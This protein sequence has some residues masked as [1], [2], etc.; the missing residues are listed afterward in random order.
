MSSPSGTAAPSVTRTGPGAMRGL[1]GGAISA[2]LPDTFA[3]VSAI[4]E[5][6]DHQE[7]F[8]GMQGSEGRE[9]SLIVE[10]LERDDALERRT[11]EDVMT[12]YFTD[13]AAHNESQGTTVLFPAAKMRASEGFM[14]C[15]DQS[16]ARLLIIGRQHVKKYRSEHSEVD[17]VLVLLALVR[18]GNVATDVLISMNI[19][20][21]P[22]LPPT[23]GAG[24]EDKALGDAIAQMM[25]LPQLTNQESPDGH[26]DDS[27]M[28]VDPAGPGNSAAGLTQTYPDLAIFRTFLSTFTINDWS[29]FL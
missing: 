23:A 3:D 19:P 9:T 22:P 28:D 6:P 13:L 20:I 15:V 2:V 1:Y 18:L 11:D 25:V 21:P 10:L 17:A 14:P 7:V 8:L 27:A 29:L 5:V 16:H 4:R 12:H 24:L 26:G